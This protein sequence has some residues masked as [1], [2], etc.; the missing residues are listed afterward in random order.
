M[1]FLRVGIDCGGT[2]TD[3]VVL[4][5]DDRV[6]GWAK[7]PASQDVLSGV[8]AAL[9]AALEHARQGALAACTFMQG[10]MQGWSDSKMAG[11]LK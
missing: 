5:P 8:V 6:L 7:R 10:V 3:A 4:G 2:N 1:P 11:A 9:A